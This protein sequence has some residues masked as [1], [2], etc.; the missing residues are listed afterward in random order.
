MAKGIMCVYA[1]I[2]LTA[3]ALAS[4]SIITWCNFLYCCSYIKLSVTLIK[5]IPQV[6]IYSEFKTVALSNHHFSSLIA[7]FFFLLC[8]QAY[9]NYTRKSTEGWSIANVLLD[10][11]GGALSV[12]QMIINGYNYGKLYFQRIIMNKL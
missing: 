6:N 1:L 7:T 4:L 8:D 3:G 12:L 9:L 11:T 10:F 5:Y 2:L